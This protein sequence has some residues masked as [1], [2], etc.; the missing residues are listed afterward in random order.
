M[1]RI[2]CLILII[3]FIQGCSPSAEE[4][5]NSGYMDGLA[6]GYNT[7]CKIGASTEKGDWENIN[8][9]KGYGNGQ[10]D[11]AAKGINAARADNCKPWGYN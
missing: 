5:Y 4:S 10:A 11:G 1:N 3:V 6:E 9:T 2:I 7:V 8:Y